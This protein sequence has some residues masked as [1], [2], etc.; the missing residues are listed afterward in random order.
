MASSLALTQWRTWLAE[1]LETL[2]DWPW[3]ETLL[4]LRLRFRE[5]RLGL[6]AGSLTFTTLIALVPLAT[7]MLAIFSAFPI[8]SSF[9][10]A[11]ER[12]F[13]QSL[14]PEAI[15]RPVL[16]A[17][18]QFAGKARDVG[19]VG[20]VL[21]GATALATMLT[22]DRSL[23][24]IWRVRQPRPIAQRVLVY[25]AALTLGPLLVGVSLSMT[26][27][28]LSVSR[29]WV[30]ALPGGLSLLIDVFEFTLL[31]AGMAGL[32]H[33]VPNTWVRWR[34][35]LAG[36]LFVAVA[37]EGAKSGLAWYLKAVPNFSAVYGT[38]ATLPILMLWIYLAWVI[39]LLGAVVA[40]YAP[41]L[42]MRVSRRPSTPGHQF[43]LALAVLQRLAA[44]H[45]DDR[46]GLTLSDLALEL[47]TDPLQ[48][49]PVLESLVALDWVG[50]LSEDGAGRFV[51]LVDPAETTSGPLIDV[52]LLAPG[53]ATASFRRRAGLDTRPLS[54]LL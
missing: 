7:V 39:V 2:R 37:F 35:A 17:L 18:T 16:R 53:P 11:L 24:A 43:E 10:G 31:A 50:G 40:A 28:A 15:A 41:S 54:E 32:F 25:W 47:R 29:G 34:H 36:G 14:V 13:F 8:F 45:A 3:Y 6:T 21:L 1:G 9:Q 44:A 27:Y 19:S 52:F 23:N 38:F 5:D 51:L 46:R 49:E 4:T 20:L 33:Y 26:S 12:Y 48:L 42:K 22:I 30:S